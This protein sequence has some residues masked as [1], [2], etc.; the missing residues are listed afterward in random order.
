MTFLQSTAGLHSQPLLIL[1]ASD[2][3]CCGHTT[4]FA[5]PCT[6]REHSCLRYLHLLFP[7][8][9]LQ[10]TSCLLCS[11]HSSHVLMDTF[12]EYT[13][14]SVVPFS[15]TLFYFFIY[16]FLVLI[17]K[18]NIAKQFLFIIYI[19][20]WNY[21][22]WWQSLGAFACYILRPG[23]CLVFSYARHK[24]IPPSSPATSPHTH[25]IF[26]KLRCNLWK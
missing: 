17:S 26:P 20:H 10:V 12:P 15:L 4:L 21:A 13:S 6:H 25:Q 8:W 16:F 7:V 9:S 5:V 23:Q 1:S 18:W 2:S 22:S 3:F 14:S 24:N 11:F 19:P